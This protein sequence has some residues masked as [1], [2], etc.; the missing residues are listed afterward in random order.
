[1]NSSARHRL[2]TLRA[3][4]QTECFDL[5]HCRRLGA[6]KMYQDGKLIGARFAVWAPNAKRVE[7]VRG[8]VAGGYIWPDGRGTQATFPMIR[9]DDGI[10]TV[11]PLTAPAL[12]DYAEFEHQ[13]YMFRITK[14]DGG[15]AYRTDLDRRCQIGSGGVN[16]E[17]GEALERPPP[18][19]GRG[20]ELFGGLVIEMVVEPFRQLDAAGQPVWPETEWLEADC[21]AADKACAFLKYPQ[22]AA[23]RTPPASPVLGRRIRPPAPPASPPRRSRDLRTAHRRPGHRPQR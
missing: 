13:T 16:P 5:T 6:N 23:H 21:A 18:G 12:S 15:V 17:A 10:W 4:G 19:P 7:L 3:G 1:M 9:G 22:R 14:D 11:D 2:F 20:Q 8:E